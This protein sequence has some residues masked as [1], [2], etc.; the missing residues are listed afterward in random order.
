MT[1]ELFLNNLTDDQSL[2]LEDGSAATGWVHGMQKPTLK[3]A[4]SIVKLFEGSDENEPLPHLALR[5][6]EWGGFLV[7]GPTGSVYQLDK[8]ASAF[9]QRL[10]SGETLT[11]IEASPAPF[12]EQEVSDFKAAVVKF[13]LLSPTR[14]D[15]NG[16]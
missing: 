11:E 12:T 9:F 1:I 5:V 8:S 4:S 13:D 6:E 7:H 3:D 2:I 10:K 14:D 16:N 15:H